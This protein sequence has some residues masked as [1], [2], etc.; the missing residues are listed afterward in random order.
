MLVNRHAVSQGNHRL[1][2]RRRPESPGHATSCL[3]DGGGGRRMNHR[4]LRLVGRGR[5]RTRAGRN[6]C[7]LGLRRRRSGFDRLRLDVDRRGGLSR[8]TPTIEQLQRETAAGIAR[9]PASNGS[10]K[11][12]MPSAP[13]PNCT[14]RN[15]LD[16]VLGKRDQR[17]DHPVFFGLHHPESVLDV[18]ERAPGTASLPTT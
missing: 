17:F 6:R 12:T 13:F 10:S 3:W 1:S 5:H 2:C 14:G 9:K 16:E 15:L 11:F 4:P 7:N 8:R 18:L